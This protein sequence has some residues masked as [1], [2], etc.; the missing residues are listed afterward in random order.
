MASRRAGGLVGRVARR[1]LGGRRAVGGDRLVHSAPLAQLPGVSPHGALWPLR[2]WDYAWYEQIAFH[3]YPIHVGRAYAFFPLWPGLLAIGS[4]LLPLAAVAAALSVAGS[5]AAFVGIA[6]LNPWADANR[7][8]LALICLPGSF[9]LAV[10]YPDGLALAASVWACLLARGGR[11]PA[12]AA[13]AAAAG[14]LRPDGYL[15]VIPLVWLARRERTRLP[16]LLALSPLAGAAAS[17]GYLCARSGTPFAFTRAQSFCHRDGP[18]ELIR[19]LGRIP[20]TQHQHAIEV[21]IAAIAVAL[22]V[23]LWRR[24]RFAYP[25]ALYSSAIVALSLASGSLLSMGRHMVEAFPLAWL[26]SSEPAIRRRRWLAPAGL[27]ANALLAVALVRY[28]P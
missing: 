12:A 1:D 8:A 3:G 4:Q 2:S 23:L 24:G 27:A 14:A 11:W 28:F 20:T 10:W 18:A 5:L 15:L 21:G 16:L 7:T 22:C 26:A 19:E 13:L 25:W 17:I 9:A 6:R